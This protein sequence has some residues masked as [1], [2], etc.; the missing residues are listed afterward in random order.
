MIEIGQ[1]DLLAVMRH[2]MLANT[3]RYL[4]WHLRAEP[5]V[6]SLAGSSTPRELLAFVSAY[7]EKPERTAEDV[8]IAYAML[9]ALSFQDRRAVLEAL[10]D[11]HPS[12]LTWAS[13]ILSI[14]SETMI[15]TTAVD[16][17]AP[18]GRIVVVRSVPYETPTTVMGLP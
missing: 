13:H 7:E 5:S 4:Y 9:V 1:I 17:K 3:P 6:A 16:W 10:A 14:I 8:A 11:W 12:A 2:Y 18:Q 15:S